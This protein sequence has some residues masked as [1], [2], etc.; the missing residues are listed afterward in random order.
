MKF[1]MTTLLVLAFT[2]F[3]NAQY[4][5]DHNGDDSDL[6]PSAAKVP[7]AKLSQL[8]YFPKQLEVDMGLN[9]SYF[10]TKSTKKFGSTTLLDYN[11]DRWIGGATVEV[12]VIDRLKIG[13]SW[14]YETD[15]ASYNV[16]F[17]QPDLKS[18]GNIDPTISATF[19]AFD[20]PSFKVDLAASIT[21]SLG[22]EK[23]ADLFHDGNELNGFN[24]YDGAI[25]LIGLVTASSQIEGSVAFRYA[26]SGNNDDQTTG[27]TTTVGSHSTIDFSAR[28]LTE[29]AQN[30]FF[31]AGVDYATTSS[32][33]SQQLATVANYGTSSVATVGAIA[34]YEVSPDNALG[35]EVAYIVNYT[36]SVTNN[37][38][39]QSGGGATVTY[40]HRF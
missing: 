13:V 14:A 35:L 11:N 27:Y 12:G 36:G 21:P 4:S 22:H 28:T 7:N 40:V 16:P 31:G 39:N 25:N 23:D 10:K 9:G 8:Q 5:V 38:L 1:V 29:I 30:L 26:D 37:D 19:R 2:S 15:D 34:R 18:S 33:T 6:T 17:N 20:G 3:A 32:Y 24:E